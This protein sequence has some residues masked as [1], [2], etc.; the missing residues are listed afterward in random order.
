MAA[1]GRGAESRLNGD[2]GVPSSRPTGH[3]L[4]HS[5]I[6]DQAERTPDATA[7]VFESETL[8]Y[9]DLN[10]RAN[11]LARRLKA[12]GIG[13][14][15]MVAVCMQRSLELAIAVLAVL[16]AGGVLVPLD[17]DAPIERLRLLLDE[18]EPAAILAQKATA[19]RLPMCC[20]IVI[21]V[22]DEPNS[23]A[24][25]DSENPRTEMT[26]ENLCAVFFTSGSTGAPKGVLVPHRVSSRVVWSQ[27]HAISFGTSVRRLLTSSLRYASFRGELCSPLIAGAAVVF[28]S[29]GGY[30]DIDYLLQVIE[31]QRITVVSFVP[32]VLRLILQRIEAEVAIKCQSLRHIFSHGEALPPELQQLLVTHLA[33]DLHKFYGLT[34]APG[35]TY[36]NCR[37][38][39]D[40]Q[41]TTIGRPT[42]MQVHLLDRNREKVPIGVPGEIY[43]G[44]PGLARGYLGRPDLTAERFVPNPFSDEPG[45]RLFR[46]GDVGRWL[47]E[48]AIEFLGRV[49]HQVKIRGMRVELGEIEAA[50]C[51]Q[52]YVREAVVVMREDRP[53]DQRLAAYVV[54]QSAETKP[55]AVAL[56]RGLQAKLPGHMIP[57]TFVLL[58]RLPL[59]LNGKLDRK[60]LPAPVDS[61][62]PAG[63][64][65][66]PPRDTV[67]LQLAA[68][69]EEVLAVR[70]VG[71]TDN[72]FEL[73]GH[74]LLI[75]RLFSRIETMFG[76]RLPITALL[77]APTIERLAALLRRPESASTTQPQNGDRT[78]KRPLFCVDF[79]WNV[80]QHLGSDFTIYELATELND[81]FSHSRI[82]SLAAE[83]VQKVRDLQPEGPYLLG[84][85]GA[86]GIVAYEMARQLT[87]QGARVAFLAILHT[88]L[89]PHPPFGSL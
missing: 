22:D 4:F 56:R 16:K 18:T 9:H 54:P 43:V 78:S 41:T 64:T 83:Y 17:P 7:V 11:Q 20:N 36:W 46:T 3:F 30:H 5:L 69:W 10:R 73:G 13:P 74:S 24:Q 31:Q 89:L 60:A 45:S 62:L 40:S 1:R 55:D 77:H 23:P 47:P 2:R 57:S 63:G 37:N 65:L 50:L 68:V 21:F 75:L 26:A 66:Q 14:E 33:A 58:H 67:E 70:S 12:L 38:G 6:E 82:E 34:E 25:E 32:S 48:G 81:V 85:Y 72:F 76:V 42:D 51:E 27:N 86:S 28:A 87:S 44:G 49:D 15:V 79:R 39:E 35:V 88:R 8:S 84:G 80:T 53:G 19:D 52:P 59:T 29:P 71:V 61:G